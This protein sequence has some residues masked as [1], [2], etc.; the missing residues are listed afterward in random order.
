[1]RILAPTGL[2]PPKV[3]DARCCQEHTRAAGTKI[4]VGEEATLRQRPLVDL[5]IDG[6]GAGDGGGTG[7]VQIDRAQR[8][9]ADGR[10]RG[11]AGNLL[12]DDFRVLLGKIGHAHCPGTKPAPGEG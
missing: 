6:R 7:V 12:T 3:P 5:E 4:G 11:D 9:D 1:M 8:S 10:Q 2:S